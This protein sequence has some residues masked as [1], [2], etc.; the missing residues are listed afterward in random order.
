[1]S[2]Q[3]PNQSH[4]KIPSRLSLAQVSAGPC[5]SFGYRCSFLA[6]PPS[7][8]WSEAR[9]V[10]AKDRVQEPVQTDLAP[11]W[12]AQHEMGTYR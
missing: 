2:N 5:R 3:S 11:P 4:V 1:M 6:A 9:N 7:F 12:F 10:S 8:H